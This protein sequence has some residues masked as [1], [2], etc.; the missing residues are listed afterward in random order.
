MNLLIIYND[1]LYHRKID[2]FICTQMY[3]SI[4]GNA[5][6]YLVNSI[7]MACDI[8]NVN[9]RSSD[10]MNVQVPFCQTDQ[11]KKSLS[12]RG[13]VLWNQLSNEIQELSTL[14]EFKHH[15]RSF[16]KTR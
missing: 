6:D 7:N 13:A 15:V 12:Y 10:T 1:N 5:P 8:N 16:V 2:Y 9:T 4:Y 11:F 3:N 14:D